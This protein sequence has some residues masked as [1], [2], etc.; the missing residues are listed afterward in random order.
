MKQDEKKG[1]P[2][3]AEYNILRALIEGT[4]DAI[5]IKDIEGRYKLV[6]STLARFIGR[7]INQ[8]IGQRDSDLY[9]PATARQFVEADRQVLDSGETRM[10]EGVA[11]GGSGTQVYR[12]TKGVIRDEQGEV[13]GVFGISHDMTDRLRAEEERLQR[14]REQVARAEAEEASRLKDE[15]L[16]TLSH[17]LRTPLTAILGWAHLLNEETLNDE[18]HTR[19]LQAI[20]R[21]ARAQQQL[22]S[23]ILDVSRIITGN[24][25]LEVQPVELM[26]LINAALDAVRPA[27]ELKSI[28]LKVAFDPEAN[29]ILGDPT[30]LQQVLWNL[31]S[32]AI[33]F[34]PGEG[35]VTIAV[36][37]EESSIR[38][39]V[40]DT[41]KG[42]RRDFLPHV[43]ERFRQ[44]DQTTTREQGGL[45]LG[46]AIVRHLVEQHGGSVAA[47]SGGEG[48]GATFAI[49]LPVSPAHVNFEEAAFSSHVKEKPAPQHAPAGLRGIRVLI[50]DDQEDA[51]EFLAAALGQHGAQVIIAASAHEALRLVRSER[52]HVLISDIGM[53]GADGYTLIR[54]IRNR[55]ESHAHALPAIALTG[56]AGEAD[57]ERAL[58]SGYQ[59]HMTKPFEL[60]ELVSAIANLSRH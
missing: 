49:E 32:N 23:D 40:S 10:F 36:M 45:G 5:F 44:A 35:H 46:L 26:P 38:I 7:P 20:E 37:R 33:K 2:Q 47:E 56:Y 53:P 55:S 43:F 15:F 30:R 48:A 28:H 52:P 3:P 14:V 54:E 19:A 41:G 59:L 29:L 18:M 24:L 12:V 34:T 13:I 11:S 57:R 51:R 27:A 31:L 6:N 16:A 21:N 25:R 1:E 58:A 8:I 17:E 9:S 39:K 60:M 50:V 42:I 4:T 22:I